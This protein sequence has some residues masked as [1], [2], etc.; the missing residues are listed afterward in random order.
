MTAVGI[1]VMC[2]TLAPLDGDPEF[3]FGAEYEKTH[4]ATC[5]D[6]LCEAAR[7]LREVCAWPIHTSVPSIFTNLFYTLTVTNML[8]VLNLHY[9]GEVCSCLEYVIVEAAH[10][11]VPVDCTVKFYFI[12]DAWRN[13][14]INRSVASEI[15]PRRRS[16]QQN[17]KNRKH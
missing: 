16:M 3:L 5:V 13:S 10:R 12:F 9:Y 8:T 1:S 17:Y 15:I 2:L 6:F 11:N 7:L 4:S 14:I